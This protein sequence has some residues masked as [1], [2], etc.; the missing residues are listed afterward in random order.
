M[1]RCRIKPSLYNEVK[2]DL[3]YSFQELFGP[4]FDVS[5][6]NVGR[7]I[8]LY[9]TMNI[10]GEER[11]EEGRIFRRAVCKIP[12]KG[13]NVVTLDDLKRAIRPRKQKTY[14]KQPVGHES[15]DLVS[16]FVSSGLYIKQKAPGIHIVR[17]PWENEH[18]TNKRNGTYILS[19]RGYDVFYCHHAHCARRRNK[20]VVRLLCSGLETTNRRS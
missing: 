19:N 9:G 3:Y 17:C 12:P 18:T 11:P 5:V 4:Q 8:R 2:D 10:K 13:W 14:N 16:I 6:R 15:Y 20:D 7:I 1:W